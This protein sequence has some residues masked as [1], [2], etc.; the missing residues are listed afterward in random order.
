MVLLGQVAAA[1]QHHVEPFQQDYLPHVLG[2][3]PHCYATQVAMHLLAV[4]ATTT[5]S[6]AGTKR[7]TL[8]VR[9]PAP[10]SHPKQSFK[11]QT[12]QATEL[13]SQVRNRLGVC[14]AAA[15][16]QLASAAPGGHAG[17]P[18]HRRRPCGACR[19]TTSRRW[20]PA[21]AL[22][23]RPWPRRARP[24]CRPRRAPSAARRA[25]SPRL[26]QSVIG[27]RGQDKGVGFGP[28]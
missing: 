9:A 11:A 13:R 25:M 15:A 19:A 20:A 2:A 7:S 14:G 6:A 28:A 21:R 26:A 27:L 1:V 22:R 10:T 23:R 4:H 12:S 16:L 17:V 3:A 18:A 24:R 8:S 5:D